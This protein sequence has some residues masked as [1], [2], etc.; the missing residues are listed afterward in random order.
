MLHSSGAMRKPTIRTDAAEPIAAEIGPELSAALAAASPGLAVTL[1]TPG[2]YGAE[3]GLTVPAGVTFRLLPGV[4]LLTHLTLGIDATLVLDRG[5]TICAHYAPPGITA[6]VTAL[7]GA[8]VLGQGILH[9]RP[10]QAAIV[11]SDG[12]VFCD[13]GITFEGLAPGSDYINAPEPLGGGGLTAPVANASLATVAQGTFKGRQAAAGTGAPQDLTAAQA[14]TALAITAGDVS[15]LA[16]VATSSSASDLTSGTL[17]AARL[18]DDSVTFAK[19]PNANADTLLG[20]GNG[21]GTGDLQPIT[22]G[23]NLSMAGTVL[24]AA[25]GGGSVPTGTG[26]RHV[27]AGSEDAAA[28][29][30]EA[31]DI[32]NDTVSFGKLQTVTGPVVAGRVT[33]T[34]GN[35]GALTPSSLFGMLRDLIYPIGT[36]WTTDNATNPATTLGFGTWAAF[37]AGRVLVG[38]DAGQTEFDTTL[39]TG[40]AKTHT[41]TIAEMPS[42]T[43]IQNA[44][45]H[46]LNEGTTDGSGTFMDRSNAAAPTTAVTNDTT[47]TNQNTGGDGAHNNLQPYIVVHFWRRTA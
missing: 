22:L 45:N 42:H 4:R 24:N 27:T 13:P 20:R 17:P 3:A 12:T 5:A 35:M 32:A 30:V 11:V 8:R 29:L 46:G 38:F 7:D 25:G 43:H 16:A 39:E 47:A 26:F 28:K 23:T 44:H 15:G 31:L 33:A 40:G 21:G 10:T 19:L 34:L 37:G 1:A 18:A 6:A 36:I 14:K 2:R 41:L 9:G